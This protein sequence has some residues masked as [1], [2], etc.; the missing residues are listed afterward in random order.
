MSWC[1]NDINL[2]TTK[3]NDGII[4]LL[5]DFEGIDSSF[6]VFTH[7]DRSIE[8]SVSSKVVSMIMSKHNSL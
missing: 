4:I 7:V 5:V 2:D 6:S 3:F 1:M 8:L